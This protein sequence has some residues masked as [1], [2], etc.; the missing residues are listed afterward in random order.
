MSKNSIAKR[1]ISRI[2]QVKVPYLSSELIILM[3][4]GLN[5]WNTNMNVV[6]ISYS[7]HFSFFFG[8]ISVHSKTIVLICVLL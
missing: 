2:F 5:W 4:H 3:P 1:L 8:Q 7:S 6:K